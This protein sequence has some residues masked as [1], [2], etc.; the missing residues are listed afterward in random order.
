MTTLS[1]YGAHFCEA[2]AVLHGGRG[3]EPEDIGQRRPGEPLEEFLARS[4][5]EALG[6]LQRRLSAVEPPQALRKAHDILLQLL[7]GAVEADVALAAQVEAY[8][9]GQFQE[10]IAHSDRL[11][12]LVT[13]SARL[14]R[15]LILA[16]RE[17]E[18]QRPGTLAELG[19]GDIVS[20]P[21]MG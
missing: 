2:Y 21:G 3:E 18:S 19:L 11:Q 15:E 7:A 17:G 6:R 4:R 13:E 10:S 9:C 16:L 5:G 1:D 8:R 12:V 20:P 14:D